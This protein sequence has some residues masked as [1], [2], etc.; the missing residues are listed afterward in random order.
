MKRGFT[1]IEVLVTLAIFS[2]FAG[3]MVPAVW[4]WWESQEV[5]TT[6]ERLNTLK[7][8]MIGDNKQVQNGIRTSF[9]FV[10]DIGELPFGNATTLSG[11]K[12]LV[13][14]PAPTYP[15]W[16]GPYISDFDRNSYAVDAW[17]RAFRYTAH[18]A[19]DSVGERYLSGEIRSAG[20]N[21]IFETDGDDIFVE[22]GVKDVAPTHR[23]QGN[24]AFNTL[25]STGYRSANFIVE[26]RRPDVA[27]EFQQVSACKSAFPN[28]TTVFPTGSSP[29][30]LPIGKITV[31]SQLYNNDTCSGS[32]FKISGGLDYFISDN[33][34]RLFINLPATP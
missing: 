28:F 2:V 10:G 22:I 30:N 24:F 32:A 23:I 14:N 5:Q 1:L 31:K 27:G 16:N 34:S 8:G 7:L 25:S 13:S 19:T 29:G 18:S 20:L 12:Y 33:I 9:G 4:K 15:N 26:Y 6:K 3:M 11:L 17:G 21:G